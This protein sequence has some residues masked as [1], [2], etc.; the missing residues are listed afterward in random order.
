M[1]EC[2]TDHNRS[3]IGS[4]NTNVDNGVDLLASV[5]LPFARSDLLRELLHVLEDIMDFINTSF[6]DLE[7]ASL[8]VSK[9]DV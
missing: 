7:S 6:V 4:T 1:L 2:F 8:R 5:S 3:Q 9:G